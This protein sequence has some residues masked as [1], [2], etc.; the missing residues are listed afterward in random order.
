VAGWRRWSLE[1]GGPTLLG[2]FELG[3][4]AGQYGSCPRSATL[5]TSCDWSRF[6]AG[7]SILIDWLQA[8]AIGAA[9]G[10]PSQSAGELADG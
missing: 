4:S 1:S 6:A 7:H 8:K 3:G 2:A 5:P 10:Q 9:V